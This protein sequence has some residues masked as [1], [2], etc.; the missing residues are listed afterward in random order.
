MLN[1]FCRRSSWKCI[2]RDVAP[3]SVRVGDLHSPSTASPR[4]RAPRPTSHELPD[5]LLLWPVA[6]GARDEAM[7]GRPRTNGRCLHGYHPVLDTK[8]ELYARMRALNFGMST[9]SGSVKFGADA[10][11]EV[12]RRNPTGRP[13]RSHSHGD[14]RSGRGS[15]STEKSRANRVDSAFSSQTRARVSAAR[16]TNSGDPMGGTAWAST[17]SAD[18]NAGGED[19]AP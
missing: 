13:T 18:A 14:Q 15:S 1:S 12:G 7:M 11:A 17:P 9:L 10:A 5:G 8:T 4:A 19:A 16:I 2:G 3:R 6:R